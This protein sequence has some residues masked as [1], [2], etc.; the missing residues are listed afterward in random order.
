MANELKVVT[1]LTCTNGNLDYQ[2]KSLST[3]FDQSTARAGTFTVDVGTSE[4]T[5]TLG[6]LSPGFCRVINL[7]STNYVELGFS[8]G[9]YGIKLRANKGVALFERNGSSTIYVKAN[10]AACKIQFEAL[11]S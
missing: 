9:V 8:T 11:N 4:E 2:G 1:Q 6:D 5:V 7:D 3:N 10:T